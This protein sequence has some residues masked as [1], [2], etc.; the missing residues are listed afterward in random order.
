MTSAQPSE[1][2][3]LPIRA[4]TRV[5]VVEDESLV[6]MMLSDML[7]DLGCTV[8]GPVG[9]RNGALALVA[10]GAQLD[11]ALLDVNLGGETAYEVADA[12]AGRAVPYVFVSGYGRSGIDPQYGA[13]PILAKPFRPAALALAISRAL[14]GAAEG[15][16]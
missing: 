1:A 6:A 2:A 8:V 15:R 14:T 13:A 11:L 3:K 7:Q 4:G 16:P 10:S 12:L 5:L 9:T